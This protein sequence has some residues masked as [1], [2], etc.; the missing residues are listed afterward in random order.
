[1]FPQANYPAWRMVMITFYCRS[2][3]HKS[4]S[5]R[6]RCQVCGSRSE[7]FC[8]EEKYGEE[9]IGL[10][11][12]KFRDYRLEALHK[13]RELRYEPAIPAIQTLMA[14]ERDPI[15]SRE[16]IRTL[17][18]IRAYQIRQGHEQEILPEGTSRSRTRFD[19]FPCEMKVI[20]ITKGLKS[21]D[22]SQLRADN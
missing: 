3:G 2:C 4:M 9:M 11:S 14:K 8:S 7:Q 18:E 12:H 1:M 6:Q 16:A 5:D 22:H 17:K 10:L 20:D 19:L 13:I 15:L 21:I